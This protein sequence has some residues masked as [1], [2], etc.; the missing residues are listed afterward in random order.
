MKTKKTIETP[1]VVLDKT[2]QEKKTKSLRP[3]RSL[4]AV[5][6]LRPKTTVAVMNLQKTQEVAERN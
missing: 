2:L 5:R 3:M 1:H 6:S 4:M